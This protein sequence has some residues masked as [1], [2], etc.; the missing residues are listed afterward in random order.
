VGTGRQHWTYV[1]R[2]DLAELY[3][4]VLER[5]ASGIFHGV[6]GRPE[7]VQDSAHALSAAAG[8]GV[9]RAIPVEEARQSM[10][11]MADALA[12]DQVVVSARAREVGWAPARRSFSEEAPQ[13]VRE[14]RGT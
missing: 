7:L 4:R 6:D 12:M 10:G 1:H 8:K 5:R 11:S 9:V 3:R 13:T 2:E 14:W